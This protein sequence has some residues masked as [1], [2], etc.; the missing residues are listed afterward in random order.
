MR[1]ARWSRL[2]SSVLVSL[3][4]LTPKAARALLIALDKADARDRLSRYVPYP[5]QLEF[6]AAGAIHRERMFMAGNQLGKTWAGGF[7]WAMHLTGRYPSWW[8][9]RT[10]DKAVRMWASGETGEATRDNPQKILIGD[11][12]RRDTWGSGAIPG[13]AIK[14]T[15]AARGTPNLL[16]SIVVRH[17]GGGD[18]QAGES[19]LLF[20]TYAMGREKWQGPTL[21]GVWYDEEPPREI[22]M[23]GLTR[24]NVLSGLSMLT[25]TP[26]Q[27]MSEVVHM[28]LDTEKVG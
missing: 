19:V 21:H 26:L 11:P 13:D 2:R 6:H 9:G 10:F 1:C 25:F 18:V 4:D 23:E 27:G 3:P 22:Y 15:T 17:G 8:P 28:F 24:T 7:E 14:D 5:Q 12:E 16:D 20:K